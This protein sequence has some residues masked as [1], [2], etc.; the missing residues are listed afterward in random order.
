MAAILCSRKASLCVT[1]FTLQKCIHN[2]DFPFGFG[3]NATCDINGLT[4]LL[5]QFLQQQF[6]S[7]FGETM[8]GARVITAASAVW[9][10]YFK[11]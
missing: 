8:Q 9:M 1:A 6:V 7:K 11:K 10:M 2:Q 3:T 4:D 5:S